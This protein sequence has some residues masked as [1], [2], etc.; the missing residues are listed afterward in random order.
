MRP[1]SDVKQN[2]SSVT[3]SEKETKTKCNPWTN[4]DVVL[5]S[6]LIIG[7][8]SLLSLP[9]IFFNLQESKVYDSTA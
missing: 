4:W 9:V 5:L 8:W 3:T 2:V 7:L 1:V 6:V